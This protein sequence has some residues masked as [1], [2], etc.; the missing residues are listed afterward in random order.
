MGPILR[1]YLYEGTSCNFVVAE[2]P[3]MSLSENGTCWVNVAASFRKNWSRTVAY[4][5]NDSRLVRPW[6]EFIPS[7]FSISSENRHRMDHAAS[8]SSSWPNVESE[9]KLAQQQSTIDSEAKAKADKEEEET[10][11]AEAKAA[12]EIVE[13][14]VEAERAKHE[15]RKKGRLEKA[16][17]EKSTKKRKGKQEREQ[18]SRPQPR[19]NQK[20][21]LLKKRRPKLKQ[22]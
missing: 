11:T 2:V 5:R 12:V 19:K 4:V 14:A 15:E 10:A 22:R 6:K 7:K 21:K 16:R 3:N 17:L 8:S 18:Q 1:F 20:R 13:K 9:K